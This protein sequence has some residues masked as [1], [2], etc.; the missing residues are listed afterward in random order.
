M[1]FDLASI[2]HVQDRSCCWVTH[3]FGRVNSSWSRD[4]LENGSPHF[5]FS[6]QSRQLNCDF[7]V[8]PAG[9]LREDLDLQFQRDAIR[10]DRDY[11]DGMNFDRRFILL[12]EQF[13]QFYSEH[14]FLVLNGALLTPCPPY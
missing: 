4:V 12:H 6:M 5:S 3:P 9:S 7:D 11:S 1:R 14:I 13:S 2:L 8:G 10:L